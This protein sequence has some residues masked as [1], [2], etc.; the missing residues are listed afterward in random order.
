MRMMAFYGK[1]GIGKST[2]VTNLSVLFARDGARVLQ[3]G[4]DPKSDSCY[5]L[6]EGRVVTVMEQWQ[7]VGE[8]E[9]RLEHCLMKTRYG[10]DCIEVGGPAPGSGCGGRGITKAFELVGDPDD[11]RERYD[12]I[13]FDVLGD[14]VCGGFSAPMRAGY[15]REIY[16]VT[17]GEL[18][19]LFAANNISQA[20][21][22]H[23]G[24][25]VRLGGIV[26]NLRGSPGET[27]R[28]DKL[29]GLIGSSVVHTIPK[30][31]D[32]VEAELKRMPLVE[33]RGDSLASEAFAALHQ[34]IRELR[35]SHLHIPR[36]L[37]RSEFDWYFRGDQT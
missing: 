2:V 33:M 35:P 13:L 9:L 25:A 3:F 21:V 10:V 19:S 4:C 6:V 29:A 23:A 24:N 8:A 15:A 37:V 30:S 14:V 28:I 22:K 7:E 26:G 20:V 31:Q 1:G 32:I 12:I 16:L 17:S 5:S 18:R 27:D 36:P 11:L 34:R